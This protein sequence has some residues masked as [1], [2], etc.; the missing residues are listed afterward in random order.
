MSVNHSNNGDTTLL[1]G[2]NVIASVTGTVFAAT[3]AMII[4]F[5]GNLLIGSGLYAGALICAILSAVLTKNHRLEPSTDR[6]FE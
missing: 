1:W 3:L 4:G 5:S 2:V 6:I